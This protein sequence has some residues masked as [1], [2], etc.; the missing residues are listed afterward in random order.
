[1]VTSVDS[2]YSTIS[3]VSE[4]LGIP[5][6]VLRYWEKHFD[7]VVVNRVSFRHRRYTRKNIEM[8]L[9][10][11]RLLYVEKM[12]IQGAKIYLRKQIKKTEQT[13]ILFDEV[14]SMIHLL[15]EVK[16]VLGSIVDMKQ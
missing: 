2:T 5:S 6:S 14:T 4:K 9:T 3:E 8:I 1:M 11:R 12:T 7:N 10:I 13:S 15:K 16:Q